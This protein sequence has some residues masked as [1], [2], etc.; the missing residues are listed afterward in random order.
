MQHLI[1]TIFQRSPELAILGVIHF[2]AFAI[3]GTLSLLDNRILLGVNVWIKPMKFA[4]SIAIYAWTMS[5]LLGYLPDSTTKSSV[6]WTIILTMAIEVLCIA[7]Q[8]ARGLQSHFNVQTAMDGAIFATMGLAIG[9]NTVAVGVVVWLFFQQLPTPLAPAYLWAIRLGL[10]IFIVASLQGYLMGGRLQHA[11]GAPDGTLGLPFLNWS[12][13][14][15]DLRVAHFIGLHAIQ[16]LPLLGFFASQHL[17]SQSAV[18]AVVVLTAVYGAL[19]VVA[20]LQ[21]LSGLP[22]LKL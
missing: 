19:C 7:G 22:L 12:R 2:I 10:M 17:S 3:F 9:I 18:V 21:A 6:V 16:I 4:V 11:V 20:L 14:V 1:Q 5:W 15:G 8:A 13:S